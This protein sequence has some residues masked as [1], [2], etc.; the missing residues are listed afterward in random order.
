[1]ATSFT[2]DYEL[3]NGNLCWK[4]ELGTNHNDNF[5]TEFIYAVNLE[6]MQVYRLDVLGDRWIALAMG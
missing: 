5:A 2:G 3:I 1:M 4:I 6:T